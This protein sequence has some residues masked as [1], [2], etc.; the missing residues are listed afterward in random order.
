MCDD[1]N[2]LEATTD[3]F[4]TL[5]F[6]ASK[7]L[8][9]ARLTVVDATNVQQEARAP[10]VQLARAHYVMPVAIVLDVPEEVCHERNAARPD[11][12]F[13]P[14]VV[15]SHSRQLR[16]SLRHLGR[17]GFRHVHVLS[18][19]DIE[20]VEIERTKLWNNRRD[21]SGPFDIIGD[22]HGC[23]DELEELMRVLAYQEV[24][25]VWRHQSRKLVFLGDLVDRGPDTPRVL[26]IVMNAVEAG[27]ALCVPGNHD[28]KLKRL[29]A[30]KKVKVAHGLE[31]TLAQFSAKD[32]DWKKRVESFLDGLISHY[33]LDDG[34]LVVAHAGLKEAMQGRAAGRVRE[35]CL[36]GETTGETDEF[37]LPVRHEWANEYRGGA[38]V[39]YGHTPVPETSWLNN[40]LN[41]DTGCVFGGKLTAL[42]WPE[43]EIVSVAAR[44]EYAAPSKPFLETASTRSAQHEHDD[45]LD[46]SDILGKR[47]LHT[48]FSPTVTIREENALA[49]LEVMSRFAADPKWLIHLPPTMSPCETS[50]EDGFLEHPAQ[51]FDYYRK[52]GAAQVVCEEKHMG[53]RAIVTVCRDEETARK[54]F[55][56]SSGDGIIT[57]RTGRR[58]FDGGTMEAALLQRPAR[59]AFQSRLVARVLVG[60]V[61]LRLR[62]DAVVGQSAG[63]DSKA[64]RAGR[65]SCGR[66]TFGSFGKRAA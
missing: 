6:I 61:L 16:R 38:A 24:D 13:G 56:V 54:R 60:L 8:Q 19:E 35:F 63:A 48:R 2:S 47:I 3:A 26:D 20:T 49:A 57:T 23:A 33:V 52:G 46:L 66:G 50:R 25:G 29:L 11:R 7:R 65:R 59:C 34:R 31:E 27:A 62:V 30:G 9:N 51:A 41:V 1:E 28:E 45:L 5:H 36:Y 58:F 53:S 4:E 21:E 12:N 22:V 32:D 43:K 44:A 39:I 42:R 10:L 37:G 64:I 17:E 55:G 14:H 18:P 15:R 40:T